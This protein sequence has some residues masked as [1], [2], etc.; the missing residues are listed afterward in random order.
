LRRELSTQQ[1]LRALGIRSERRGVRWSRPFGALLIAVAVAAAVDPEYPLPRSVPE[2]VSAGEGAALAPRC[3]APR[4]KVGADPVCFR[5][6]WDGAPPALDFVLLDEQ[7]DEVLRQRVSGSELVAA[8]ELRERL[9]AGGQLHWYVEGEVAGQ[10]V[11]CAPVAF[12]F[13]R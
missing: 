1:R 10:P 11:R 7:L 13:C 4:G 5:W 3:L 9:Q 8:G 12:W 2:I 6:A